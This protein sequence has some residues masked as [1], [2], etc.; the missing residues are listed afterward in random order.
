MFC[1]DGDD[2]SLNLTSY[3]GCFFGEGAMR[4]TRGV[5]REHPLFFWQFVNDAH[6]TAG[7][8]KRVVWLG[9]HHLRRIR[10]LVDGRHSLPPFFASARPN[11]GRCPRPVPTVLPLPCTR[12]LDESE[13]VVNEGHGPLEVRSPG[14][15]LCSFR[16]LVGNLPPRATAQSMRASSVG[17]VQLIARTVGYAAIS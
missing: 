7:W 5:L 14:A 17:Y 2:L 11:H 9:R 4:Q 1:R 8:L 16:L 15:F 13:L 12:H 3:F 10:P 6:G